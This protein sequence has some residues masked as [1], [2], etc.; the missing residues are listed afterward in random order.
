M[1]DM[2]M[3]SQFMSEVRSPH[4]NS[5]LSLYLSHSRLSIN[6]P[7]TEIILLCRHRFSL[8]KH[9]RRT[10]IW[11]ISGCTKPHICLQAV[12]IDVTFTQCYSNFQVNRPQ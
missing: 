2:Q 8:T 12:A 11:K 6:Q 5:K 9:P 3:R 4:K 10:H 1:G 7:T